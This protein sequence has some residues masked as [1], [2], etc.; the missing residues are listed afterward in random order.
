MISFQI[1]ADEGIV[2]IEP[3]GPLERSDFERLT[4]EVDRHIKLKG[5]LNGVLIHARSF[6]GWEDFA[7]FTSHMK[8]VKDH[9]K[10]VKRVAVVADSKL[11]TIGPS[12]AKHFVSAEIK[13]FDYGEMDAAHHWLMSPVGAK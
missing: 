5:G 9:H 2:I 8:F 4:T 12:I 6:P 13:H 1:L 10:K 7:G 3:S 11:L